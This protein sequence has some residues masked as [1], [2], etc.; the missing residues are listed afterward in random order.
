MI[1]YVIL[2]RNLE[3]PEDGTTVPKHVG[4]FLVIYEH[5]NYC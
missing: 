4:A 2:A 1:I 3:L 5:F